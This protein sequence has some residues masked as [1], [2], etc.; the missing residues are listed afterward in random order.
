M[1][2]DVETQ[3]LPPGRKAHTDLNHSFVLQRL[4]GGFFQN[5]RGTHSLTAAM[6]ITTAN[7]C[8]KRFV[9]IL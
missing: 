9:G 8:R 5:I 2:N 3:K 6:A 1:R 4:S 7:S